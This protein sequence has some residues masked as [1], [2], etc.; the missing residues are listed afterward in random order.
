L[1]A[2]PPTEIQI[3]NPTVPM[4][5]L[6]R[7]L[8]MRQPLWRSVT[9]ASQ[10]SGDRSPLGDEHRD[11]VDKII[12]VA[13]VGQQAAM[14]LSTGRSLCKPSRPDVQYL[15]EA[16]GE[17]LKRIEESFSQYTARPSLLGP[18]ARFAFGSLGVASAVLPSRISSAVLAGMQEAM[19]DSINQQLRTLHEKNLV[20]EVPDLR[21]ALR[22]LRDLPQRAATPFTV[23]VPDLLSVMQQKE[24]TA[25]GGIAAL[26][27]FS[28]STMLK[29]AEKV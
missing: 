15:Q 2:T 13:L 25:S 3:F 27:K 23:S 19:T 6:T 10:Q 9:N 11:I 16:E 26:V 8:S 18:V 22:E 17:G 7:S 14:A 29:A 1:Q 4:R 12:R 5:Q 21:N 28:T 24:V 20:D